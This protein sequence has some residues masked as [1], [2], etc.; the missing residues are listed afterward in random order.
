MF[1]E[2]PLSQWEEIICVNLFGT[3]QL[4]QAVVPG[5]RLQHFGRIVNI[6]SDVALD[7]MIGS[8]PYGSLKAAF[9][10]L[11]ANLVTELS[12]DNILTNVVIPSWTLTDRAKKFFPVAFQKQ[13]VSAF[14]TGRVTRPEDVASLIAY[15]GSAANGHIN[16]ECIKATGKGSQ[17]MLAAIFQEFSKKQK[18]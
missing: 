15:L 12:A 18:G 4:T 13:A 1:E 7:S 6:S 10:G 3:V 11:T 5:M 14:P 9:F 17:A 8:G 2:I 16:G